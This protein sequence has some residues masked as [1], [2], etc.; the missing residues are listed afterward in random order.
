MSPSC[1]LSLLW[2]HSNFSCS[3]LQIRLAFLAL[4]GNGNIGHICS[5]LHL[6]EFRMAQCSQ[7]V[8]SK[9][10]KPRIFQAPS[11][12]ASGTPFCVCH[13]VIL[14]NLSVD[15]PLKHKQEPK[16]NTPWLNPLWILFDSFNRAT[17]SVPHTVSYD[18]TSHHLSW[19]FP[20]NQG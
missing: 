14:T 15:V 9:V 2:S 5:L 20:F 10:A 7:M 11:F 17:I 1:F 8:R 3:C 12:T 4:P 19:N 16:A 6:C 18:F 13:Q